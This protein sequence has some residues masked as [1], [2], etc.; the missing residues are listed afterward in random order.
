VPVTEFVTVDVPFG[1]L[2]AALGLAEV[3]ER[4]R[5]HGRGDRT[6]ATVIHQ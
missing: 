4:Q 1:S 6:P 5:T 3:C 2:A